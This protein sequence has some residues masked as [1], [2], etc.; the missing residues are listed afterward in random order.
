MLF[1]SIS[2]DVT[3]AAQSTATVVILMAMSKL[4]EITELFGSHGKGQTPM[5][6]V[7]DGCTPREK[8]VVGTVNSIFEKAQTAGLGNPAI[9]VIG[10]VVGLH[11]AF[12]GRIANRYVVERKGN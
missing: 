5:M 3:L 6:I 10:E 1:R 11:V 12:A 7:Q 9:M 2:G 8:C 4:K